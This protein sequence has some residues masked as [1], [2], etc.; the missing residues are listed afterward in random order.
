MFSPNSVL[1]S[2]FPSICTTSIHQPPHFPNTS[3]LPSHLLS[4]RQLWVSPYTCFLIP[5]PGM[6]G[7]LEEK[8]T[9]ISGNFATKIYVL[10]LTSGQLFSFNFLESICL[11]ALI[12]FFQRHFLINPL[13]GSA[14]RESNLRHQK[15]QQSVSFLMDNS[16]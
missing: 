12:R 16:A 1:V 10:Q 4:K 6:P 7:T 3:F 13:R 15:S 2:F 14:S 8:N 9:T 11:H 5:R